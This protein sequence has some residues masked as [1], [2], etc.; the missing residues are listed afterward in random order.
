[1]SRID[2]RNVRSLDPG[3]DPRHVFLHARDVMARYGWGKTKGYQNLKDRD[4]IPPPVMTHP[5][6]WRLDHLLSWEDKRME[7]AN[8]ALEAL[9]RLDSEGT[10]LSQMLPQAKR[11]RRSA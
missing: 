3:V 7:L 5:D 2:D 1:M 4:L 10:S 11:R 8:A 6:R 9:V